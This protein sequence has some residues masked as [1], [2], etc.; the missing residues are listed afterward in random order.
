FGPSF[1]EKLSLIHELCGVF[2]LPAE[3]HQFFDEACSI[4]C[5]N[6][7]F[8]LV[9]K[10]RTLLSNPDWRDLMLTQLEFDEALK[11]VYDLSVKYK[12]VGQQL[13]LFSKE[14]GLSRASFHRYKKMLGLARHYSTGA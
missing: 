5:T 1:A 11:L 2:E 8:R 13:R 4:Y 3:A 7:D 12:S 9:S 10:L 14:T 6:V